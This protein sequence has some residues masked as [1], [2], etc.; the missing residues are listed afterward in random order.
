MATLLDREAVGEPV[1]QIRY[2]DEAWKR[3]VERK[4]KP[5]PRIAKK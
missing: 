1:Y 5:G 3:A 2:G 4:R